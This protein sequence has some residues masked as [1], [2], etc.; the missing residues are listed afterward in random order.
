[1]K[2]PVNLIAALEAKASD[3]HANAEAAR[4]AAADRYFAVAVRLADGDE[5]GGVHPDDL[6]RDLKLLGWRLADLHEDVASLRS[7]HAADARIDTTAKDLEAATA[8]RLKTGEEL[9]V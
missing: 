1:M 6:D 2:K 8:T 7:I 4:A 9:S 5:T 3:A